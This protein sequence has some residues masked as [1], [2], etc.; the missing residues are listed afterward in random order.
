[1]HAASSLVPDFSSFVASDHGISASEA[2]RLIQDWL[3]RYRP[4]AR[5]PIQF[6]VPVEDDAARAAADD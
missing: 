4:Q 6:L 5:R 2:E 3:L 1:M